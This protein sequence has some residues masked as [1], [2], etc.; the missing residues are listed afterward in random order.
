MPAEVRI[1]DFATVES[2]QRARDS[3]GH[4]GDLEEA[5]LA[6]GIDALFLLLKGAVVEIEGIRYR[7][8]VEGPNA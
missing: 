2:M 8:T 7:L 5:I 4:P 1:L 6:T 3:L